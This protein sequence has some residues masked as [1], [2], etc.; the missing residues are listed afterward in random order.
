MIIFE[1]FFDLITAV[2]FLALITFFSSVMFFWRKPESRRKLRWVCL[3]LGIYN[4]FIIKLHYNAIFLSGPLSG[5][6]IDSETGKPIAGV[7][8]VASWS[9]GGKSPVA[10]PAWTYILG[11]FI[12]FQC[13]AR[14]HTMVTDAAG[15]FSSTYWYGA[16]VWHGCG[17][18]FYS[19]NAA[20]Y[21]AVHYNNRRETVGYRVS[22]FEP[23][24]IALSPDSPTNKKQG[25]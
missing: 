21:Q 4:I 10:L 14:S 24:R 19:T 25:Y 12:N 20:G 9:G 1:I 5:A 7:H 17:S 3:I 6:V 15:K 8:V 2:P 18:G 13:D 16:K 11:I 22:L 23:V